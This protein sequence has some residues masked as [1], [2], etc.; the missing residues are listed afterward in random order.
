ML[1]S[2][3]IR[4]KNSW[5]ATI[6]RTFVAISSNWSTLPFILQSNEYDLTLCYTYNSTHSCYFWTIYY[7]ALF[8]VFG[9]APS[10]LAFH[11]NSNSLYDFSSCFFLFVFRLEL[12]CRRHVPFHGLLMLEFDS[13]S[14]HII[15]QGRKLDWST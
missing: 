5:P 7:V 2:P 6:F 3:M 12:S 4:A 13:A 9:G 1:Q 11:A 14:A 8:Y 15:N 10:P